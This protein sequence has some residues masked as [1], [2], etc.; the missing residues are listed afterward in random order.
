MKI[1]YLSIILS[2]SLL[3]CET[4]SIS[5]YSHY[6]KCSLTETN[7]KKISQCGKENRFNYLQKIKYENYVKGGEGDRFALWVDLL[8][9]RVEKKEITETNAKM[10][11]IDKIAEIDRYYG[12]QQA[13][14][15]R[16]MINSLPKP[17]NCTSTVYGN[18]VSTS[19]Y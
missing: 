1:I 8:N 3:G 13:Q 18:S 4:T 6:Q 11:L 12:T 14:A 10:M 2:F 17:T 15:A 19:C 5:Y 9:E 7:I 16:D